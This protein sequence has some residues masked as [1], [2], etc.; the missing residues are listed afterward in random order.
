ME[1]HRKKF[2]KIGI[3]T[4]SNATQEMD[5]C[6]V[7]CLKDFNLRLG[8][9]QHYPPDRELRLVGIL[10]CAGCPTRIYPEKI[11]RKVASLVK[12]GTTHLHFANC[13]TAFCPFIRSY[14]KVIGL[15]YPAIEIIEGTHEKHITDEEFRT[16]TR[17]A[18]ET[19]RT[20]PDV[21]LEPL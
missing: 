5:C 7:A 15:K 20:M 2:I 8:D 12:F 16:R 3:I 6:A 14:A 10:S 4:C 13:M 17:C 9:F 18:L 11:L 1:R 19:N 21:I